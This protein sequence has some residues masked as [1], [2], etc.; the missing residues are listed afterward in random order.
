MTLGAFP[1][2]SP[3]RFMPLRVTK[4]VPIRPV[5][6]GMERER[7]STASAFEVLAPVLGVPYVS[8]TQNQWCWAAVAEMVARFLGNTTVSQCQLANVLHN[9]TNCCT[10]PGSTKCNQP[11]DYP[12]VF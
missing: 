12:G 7:T 11:T 10:S 1:R 4:S 6:V 8:Q 9:Q 2:I 3:E 5:R